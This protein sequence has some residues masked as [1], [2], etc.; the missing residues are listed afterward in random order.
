MT[1]D[2]FPINAQIRRIPPPPVGGWQRGLYFEALAKTP[3]TY[4]QAGLRKG[5]QISI[6]TSIFK[7]R[8]KNLNDPSLRIRQLAE[9]TA[10]K[11]N[12]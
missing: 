10:G 3:L 8:G 1:N 9:A 12:S 7:Q 11:A 2:K 4:R 6:K 5:R